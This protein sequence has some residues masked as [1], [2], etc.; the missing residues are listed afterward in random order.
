MVPLYEETER[1]GWESYIK[2]YPLEVARK[3]GIK[4]NKQNK[5]VSLSR[6]AANLAYATNPC[7][8]G[9]LPP[10]REVPSGST[11]EGWGPWHPHGKW[12]PRTTKTERVRL[13]CHFFPLLLLS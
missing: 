10:L 7:H 2:K 13:A 3:R 5:N 4:T 8:S 9:T 6:A 1:G 12:P 11:Q